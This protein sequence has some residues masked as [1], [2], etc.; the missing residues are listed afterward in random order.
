M[1]NAWLELLS[2]ETR[3]AVLAPQRQRLALCLEERARHVEAQKS[4]A[5]A[6]ARAIAACEA[7]IERARADIFRANDGVVSREMTALEREWRLLARRD[8]D[9]GMMDLWSRVAPPSWI[10]QKRWRSSA[11]AAQVDA[12][13]ALASDVE[14]IEEAEAAIAELRDA[15]APFGVTLGASIGFRMMDRDADT[16]SSL[17]ARVLDVARAELV[18]A[19][20]DAPRVFER[21]AILEEELARA[22][23]DALRDRPAFA[24]AIAHAAFV[25]VVVGACAQLP[26]AQT[27]RAQT[28]R[29][30]A[31][32]KNPTTSLRAL[33]ATGYTIAA[34]DASGVIVA[35]PPI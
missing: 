34:A 19:G 4:R 35:L 24:R 18:D 6:R 33:W 28:Q 25:D 30:P 7:R 23:G 1:Q 31:T 26:R 9:A 27:P 16:T 29:A 2:S 5:E 14:G 10:D 3:S 12:A 21:A 22:F 32:R 8:P 15:L 13:V 17:L 20:V 11:P